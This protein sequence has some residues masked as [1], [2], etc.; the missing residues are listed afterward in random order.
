MMTFAF[1]FTD[2]KAIESVFRVPELAYHQSAAAAS[3]IKQ[4]PPD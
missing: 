1:D 3:A 2:Q 4:K